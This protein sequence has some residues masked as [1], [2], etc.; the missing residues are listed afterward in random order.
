[1]STSTVP[2]PTRRL[3]AARMVGLAA[4]GVLQSRRWATWGSLVLLSLNVGAFL[5]AIV[6]DFPVAASV[7]LWNL[8]H[9]ANEFFVDDTR[10]ARA[11]RGQEG[12]PTA[13]AVWIQRYGP[14]A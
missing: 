9:V 3:Q 1:M 13:D 12:T 10:T 2:R 4:L 5:P 11:R 6:H 7:I 14:A 8:V